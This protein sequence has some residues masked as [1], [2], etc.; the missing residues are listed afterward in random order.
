M[1]TNHTDS[2]FIGAVRYCYEYVINI[3]INHS[4][5]KALNFILV[6]C[7][8]STLALI[9]VTMHYKAL[10]EYTKVS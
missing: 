5:M 3:K 1:Y 10:K 2:F 4:A 7:F 6:Y 9:N 8:N